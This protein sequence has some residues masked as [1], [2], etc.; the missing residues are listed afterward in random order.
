MDKKECTQCGETKDIET[1]FYKD[2]GRPR[3]NCKT[4]H[5]KANVCKTEAEAEAKRVAMRKRYAT[6][7]P[8]TGKQIL[9]D[10]VKSK[11]WRSNNPPTD[12]ERKRKADYA[13]EWRE[14]NKD[15]VNDKRNV[16]RALD[17]TTYRDQQNDW[18]RRNP[19]RKMFTQA[20]G[21]AKKT[22]REFSITFDD[23]LPLPDVCPVLGIPLRKGEKTGDP[24][25]YSLDR[26]DNTK[27]YIP[28]NV[29][30]ISF[31]A[32]MLKRDA[33]PNEVYALAAWLKRHEALKKGNP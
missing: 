19:H 30:V 25:A 17:P 13:R 15:R 8:K 27:G 9:G 7:P 20:K 24:N 14:E 18:N 22:G 12:E 21:R 23:I 32:N 26:I 3:S 28:G 2:K 29:A 11:K 6:L 16:K 10:R 1:G 33:T 4:C 5:I 31:R